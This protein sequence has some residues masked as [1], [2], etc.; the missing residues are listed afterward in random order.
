MIRGAI[1]RLSSSA[2]PR[3]ARV[4]LVG[5]GGWSQGWHLPNLNARDDAEIAAIID[6]LPS[7]TS[8]FLPMESLDDLS[9]RYG[10][11]PLYSSIDELLADDAMRHSLDG[12]LCATFHAAHRDIGIKTLEAGLHLLM[13]KVR[14]HGFN[15]PSLSRTRLPP[16]GSR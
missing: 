13:E 12:V 3:R 14:D 7:P 1:R 6:P 16:R 2:A 5:A 10:G 4:A 8:T 15:A 11:V 9:A